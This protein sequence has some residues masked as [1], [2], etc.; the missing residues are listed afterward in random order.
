MIRPLWY[1]IVHGIRLTIECLDV[2]FKAGRDWYAARQR[3]R[4]DDKD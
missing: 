1:R 4:E 3:E 2:M